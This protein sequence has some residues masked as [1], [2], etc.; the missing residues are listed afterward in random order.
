MIFRL[1]A[2]TFNDGGVLRVRGFNPGAADLV[3]TDAQRSGRDGV[4]VGE[5]FLGAAVWAFDI[6]TRAGDETGAL[7]ADAS[8]HAEWNNPAVRSSPNTTV[9]L[10]YLASGRW[11]RVYGR[12]GKYAGI[13]GDTLSRLG[14]GRITCDFR[15]TDPLHYD[16]DEST[17][18]LTIVPAT[19]GGLQTP[20]VFPLSTVRSSAPRAGTVT[21]GGD[22]ATPLKVVFRGPITDPWVRATGLEV[23][24][25]GTLAYDQ[26]VTVDPLAGTITGLPAGVNVTR[27]TRLTG[28]LLPPG[29]TELTF[30]GTD[31]TGTATATLAWRNAYTS[32]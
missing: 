29:V 2:V 14:M 17:V 21:N 16:E 10:S 23:G 27:K 18:R 15:V 5:D 24:L 32:I 7:A 26:T 19:T 22:A 4:I 9:P 28:T 30:G 31:P 13:N 8:L 1:G 20:F 25:V 3:V 11:R 12:P 6:T